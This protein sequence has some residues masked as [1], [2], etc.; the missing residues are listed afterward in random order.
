MNEKKSYIAERYQPHSRSL[1]KAIRVEW[2]DHQFCVPFLV[3]SH[4]KTLCL[5][6]LWHVLGSCG[7][8]P[9]TRIVGGVAAKH[10][11]WPWQ[12]MLRTSS[13]FPYC[14]GTLVSPQWVVSAAHCVRGKQPS[15]VFIRYLLSSFWSISFLK[16]LC[17][18]TDVGASCLAVSYTAVW[19]TLY[20]SNSLSSRSW[21][22]YLKS[23]DNW[24]A[25]V[26]ACLLLR[27]R[28]Q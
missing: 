10:G 1:I 13:G 23:P 6:S 21:G 24:R 19:L 25:W 27:W 2:L 26:K 22:P 12:A 16:K 3:S 5:P 7:I 4:P 11:D 18:N 20:R 17:I 28:F 14:G 8:R 15:S 9:S